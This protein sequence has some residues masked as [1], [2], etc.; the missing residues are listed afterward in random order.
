MHYVEWQ[1]LRVSEAAERW[2]VKE[3]TVRAWLLARRISC[4]RVGK[5]AIRIPVAEV[6]RLISEGTLPARERR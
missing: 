5:R 4:V 6:E 3:S 2:A 1:L